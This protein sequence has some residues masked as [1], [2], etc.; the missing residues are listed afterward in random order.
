L[1]KYPLQKLCESLFSLRKDSTGLLMLEKKG[2][3]EKKK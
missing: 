3:R 1:F 2:E